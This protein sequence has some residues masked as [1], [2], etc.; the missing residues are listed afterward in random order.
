MNS[1]L[2]RAQQGQFRPLLRKAFMADYARTPSGSADPEFREWYEGELWKAF[3]VRSTTELVWIP[4]RFDELMLHFGTIAMDMSV[5]NKY[6]SGEE[7]R[8]RF[9]IMSIM[10]DLSWLERRTVDWSYVESIFLQSK[11]GAPLCPWSDATTAMLKNV[12]MMLDTHVR[13]LAKRHGIRP[14]DLPSRSNPIDPGYYT[15]VKYSMSPDSPSAVNP[16]HA[17]TPQFLP[18]CV[19]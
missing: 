19:S 11:V 6:S 1:G 13:R 14:R 9:S 16:L 12:L 4:R 3:H 5:L 7:R 8:I 2:S 10:V 18:Y 17:R 15:S